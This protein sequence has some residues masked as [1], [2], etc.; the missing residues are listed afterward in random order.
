MQLFRHLSWFFRRYWY[1]YSLALVMLFI[2]ALVN[3]AVPQLIGRAID[4]LLATGEQA[5]VEPFLLGLVAAGVVVY[6]L[7]YGWR[8]M[9]FGTS[10]KLGNYLRR[11]FYQRLTRQGQAFYNGHSTG[12]LMARHQ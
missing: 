4:R 10:Y 5:S 1:T 3:M 7:R 12:D 9:L 11:D 2:V 6:L 8:R